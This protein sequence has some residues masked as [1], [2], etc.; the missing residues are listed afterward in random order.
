MTELHRRSLVVA[1]NLLVAS[2]SLFGCSLERSDSTRNA[3]YSP[4]AG[5][6]TS[7]DRK[8]TAEMDK[9]LAYDQ[10]CAEI[11]WIG[12]AVERDENDPQ[13]PAVT[14]LLDGA[15][16]SDKDLSH[17]EK[18][19]DLQRLSLRNSQISDA[20]LEHLR[21]LHELGW[22][23]LSQT[24]VTDRGLD[25]LKDLSKIQELGLQGT[26]I[27]DEGLG[28]LRA[29]K[30]CGSSTSKTPLRPTRAWQTSRAFPNFESST[31][32]GLESPAPG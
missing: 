7:A 4:S 2:L 1:G 11:R 6:V 32:A 16:I 28:F 23:Y 27:S 14:V 9:R 21:G 5:A 8:S 20:G 17:V 18:L 19:V 12:G 26:R 25:Q 15:R 31:S 22:L 24:Q 3:G 13:R 30:G 10:A 29:S